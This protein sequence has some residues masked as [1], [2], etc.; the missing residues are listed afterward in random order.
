MRLVDLFPNAPSKVIEGDSDDS[1]DGG[2]GADV[3][4]DL[5]DSVILRLTEEED[6][7]DALQDNLDALNQKTLSS[8]GCATRQDGGTS[9]TKSTRP[10]TLT[11]WL[12]L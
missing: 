2:A 6:L 10:R 8:D 11:R 9:R 1:D 5:T 12:T 7:F 4:E 3:E